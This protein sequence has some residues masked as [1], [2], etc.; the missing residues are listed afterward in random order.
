MLR[1]VYT[2][3]MTMRN[4]AI[5]PSTMPATTPGC[6]DEFCAPYEDGTDP[7]ASSVARPARRAMAGR[8]I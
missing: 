8:A 4:P 3:K 1:H 6:G 5:D 7:V 2:T